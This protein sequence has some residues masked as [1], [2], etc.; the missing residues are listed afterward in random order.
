MPQ[1]KDAQMQTRKYKENYT[2]K[3]QDDTQAQHLKPNYSPTD[4]SPQTSKKRD[5]SPILFDFA[6]NNGGGGGQKAQNGKNER[7]QV[8]FEF[9]DASGL[10]GNA[11]SKEQ[12][13]QADFWLPKDKRT[14]DVQVPN[15]KP[16]LSTQQRGQ[17]QVPKDQK[18]EPAAQRVIELNDTKQQQNESAPEP[19]FSDLLQFTD[20]EREAIAEMQQAKF[21]IQNSILLIHKK[22]NLRKSIAAAN[23]AGQSEKALMFK[24]ELEI[25]D[26][27]LKELSNDKANFPNG[28]PSE[29][30]VIDYQRKHTPMRRNKKGGEQ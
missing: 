27:K 23:K 17:W 6:Q 11:T 4:N 15:Y 3:T 18:T 24:K 21:P 9:I 30:E 2:S 8:D 10:V 20:E 7:K 25:A 12:T 29:A 1:Q 13:L 14:L 19:D 26:A 16:N 28:L 22:L 5:I